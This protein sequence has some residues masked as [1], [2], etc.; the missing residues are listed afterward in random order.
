MQKLSFIVLC[1]FVSATVSFAQEKATDKVPA[2]K[3]HT[4]KKHEAVP[5]VPP[6]MRASEVPLPIGAPNMPQLKPGDDPANFPLPDGPHPLPVGIDGKPVLPH[7]AQAPM[8]KVAPTNTPDRE[9]GRDRRKGDAIANN[10]I[11]PPVLPPT[12][13]RQQQPNMPLDHLPPGAPGTPGAPPLHPPVQEIVNVGPNAGSF[14]FTEETHNYG[15]VPEGNPVE[16]DF[17]FKN[18]GKEAIIIKDAKGSCGC[19]IPT[20]PKEPIAPGKS[21]VIHVVYNTK[22]RPGIISKEV[23]ITS[24]AKQQPMTLHIA[25]EVKET[26]KQQPQQPQVQPQPQH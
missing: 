4:T 16:C 11:P 9:K 23:T 3:A 2:K 15:T 19:T 14:Q 18:V 24:N 7:R 12:P 22:N 21:G 17:Y 10:A 5:P 26:Q 20:Y 13:G 8:G 6:P 25:G 1:L